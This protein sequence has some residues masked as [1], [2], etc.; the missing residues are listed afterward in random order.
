MLQRSLPQE[1]LGFPYWWLHRSKPASHPSPLPK[2]ADVVVIGAGFTGLHSALQLA[3]AG[4]TVVILEKEGLGW[5]AS[6]RNAGFIGRVL[7]HPFTV[8]EKRHGTDFA[9]AVYR[10][11]D[12][13]FL[14]LTNWIQEEGIKCE[15]QLK[16][17][18]M[19]AT[20]ASHY[21]AMAKE[22]DALHR[23]LG[24][25]FEMVGRAGV[26]RMLST[27]FYAGGAVSDDLGG[28]H[29]GLLHDALLQKAVAAGVHLVPH[30]T[31]IKIG[32]KQNG[33]RTM[34]TTS[35]DIDAQNIIVATNGYSG[36]LLPWL[37]RRL[38]PFNAFMIATEELP[39]DLIARAIPSSR[40]SIDSSHNPLY[41][42]RSP[43][44]SRVLFGGF[45]GTAPATVD[46][47][48]TP[49]M[50][51]LQTLLPDLR[52]TRLGHA[53][54]GRCAAT[55]DLFPHVGSHD[56]IHFSGGYCFA[57]VTM[58]FHLGRKLAESIIAEKPVR[59]VFADRAFPTRPLYTGNPWFMPL[60]TG[61][62][63]LLDSGNRAGRL[64]SRRS[65]LTI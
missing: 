41:V 37:S 49:L 19:P 27:D 7:K 31:A 56:G 34:K 64:A 4:R 61:A 57:G 13:A 36:A 47:V 10:E 52:N 65:P 25:E 63:K 14:G 18:F 62:Y 42:R 33:S 11:L 40:V 17:R 58:S 23:H 24:F 8:L 53:W 12:E 15:L 28:L 60:V 39:A 3:R 20:C 16:G 5:G 48:A 46:S 21:E 1:A 32:D 30:T 35:G 6:T 50:E 44:G 59:S 2:K 45:T 9:V 51:V 22:M 54:T 26:N 43:D 38:I 55:F 29:P